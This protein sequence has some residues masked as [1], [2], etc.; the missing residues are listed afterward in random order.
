MSIAK[1][2]ENTVPDD[3]GFYTVFRQIAFERVTS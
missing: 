3:I 1:G 2:L